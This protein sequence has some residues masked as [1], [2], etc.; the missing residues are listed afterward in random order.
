M[1][2]IYRNIKTKYGENMSQTVA[3]VLRSNNIS[4]KKKVWAASLNDI[5]GQS[6]NLAQNF[7]NRDLSNY[8]GELESP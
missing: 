2:D 3:D 7:S 4:G 1:S 6:K 8:S 5:G